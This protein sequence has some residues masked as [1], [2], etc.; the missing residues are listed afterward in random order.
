[1]LALYKETAVDPRVGAP[2]VPPAI[3]IPSYD[4][5]YKRSKYARTPDSQLPPRDEASF[6]SRL[7]ASQ[8]SIYF[9]NFK[10]YPR[11]FLWRVLDDNKILEIRCADVAKSGH[12]R[13]EAA[14]I[15][16]LEFQQSILPAG[17]AFADV[18]DQDI[19]HAFVLTAGKTLY[20]IALSSEVFRRPILNSDN[21][22]DWC[23]RFEPSSFSVAHPHRLQASTP[24]ELFVSL[25]SGAL[26]R[27]VRKAGQDGMPYNPF[28][29]NMLTR[30]LTQ[31]PPGLRQRTTTER[32]DRQYAAW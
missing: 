28:S 3:Q 19:L 10:S 5:T 16:R 1:M 30:S 26:L 22:G 32:G 25:D 21:V 8:S 7:L 12:E 4:G 9:R 15:L 27:L 2:I 20:T 29:E 13:T 23:K 17:V 11:T 6:S 31:D 24:F 14:Q 18:E